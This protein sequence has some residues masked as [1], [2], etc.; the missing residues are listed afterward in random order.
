MSVSNAGK[1][2]HL[3][4]AALHTSLRNVIT[5]PDDK[6]NDRTR[7]NGRFGFTSFQEYEPRNIQPFLGEDDFK[8][9]SQSMI[10]LSSSLDRS[11]EDDQLAP[12]SQSISLFLYEV[13]IGL[14]LV[15]NAVLD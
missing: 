10:H 6:D 9:Q 8:L 11:S 7:N 14:K 4:I 12:G 15:Q 5:A 1:T 13:G 2:Y 3:Q